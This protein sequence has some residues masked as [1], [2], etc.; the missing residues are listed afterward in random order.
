MK[1]SFIISQILFTS[2]NSLHSL[3]LKTGQGLLTQ[4]NWQIVDW[5]IGPFPYKLEGIL[6]SYST[7]YVGLNNPP[8]GETHLET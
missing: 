4:N 1:L 8:R 6:V 7:F 5:L 3:W 2:E